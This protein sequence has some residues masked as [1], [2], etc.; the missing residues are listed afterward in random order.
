MIFGILC[1]M[2]TI[3]SMSI[4]YS[5]E[6]LVFHITKTGK[7]YVCIL[8]FFIWGYCMENWK[9]YEKYL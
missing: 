1:T 8:I 9:S 7:Y 5:K 6:R 3:F 4:K 2:M